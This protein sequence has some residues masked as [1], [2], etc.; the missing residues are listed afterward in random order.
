METFLQSLRD[1]LGF[2]LS[3]ILIF[4]GIL[5][6]ARLSE[7]ILKT[8]RAVRSAKYISVTAVCAALSGILML[9]EIPLFFAPVFYKLDFSE[10]PVLFCGFLFGP[11]SGVLCELL[12]V[13][14]KLLLKGTETAYV[15]EFANFVVGCS[16]VLPAAITYHVRKTKQNALLGVVL[17]TAAMTAFGSLFNALYLL[18]KFALLYGI[19]MDA[20]ISMGSQ[21]NAA[22]RDVQTL[23]LY[24]VVPF[25]LL[26]GVAVSALTFLLYKRVARI[27]FREEPKYPN[28]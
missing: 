18:P 27:L 3:V 21:V 1:N 26:K 9:L 10:L 12:K 25:N 7:I 15:G 2:V 17:G 4:C 11:V 5:L 6:V 8:K 13:F 22:I 16:F 20:I 28:A 19:P 24:A 23:V 14:I